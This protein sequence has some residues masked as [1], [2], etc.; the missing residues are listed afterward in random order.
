MAILSAAARCVATR[1][2]DC[3]ESGF[4][5][6]QIEGFLNQC[7]AAEPDGIVQGMKVQ[8]KVR[9]GS[10]PGFCRANAFTWRVA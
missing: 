7:L 5:W 8:I 10:R 4:S 9:P 1:A 6:K 2:G 3:L